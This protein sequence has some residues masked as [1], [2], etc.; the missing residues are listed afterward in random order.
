MPSV[1]WYLLQAAGHGRVVR[2]PPH[3]LRDGVFHQRDHQ[4]SAGEQP[5]DRCA[6]TRRLPRHRHGPG[7]T[8]GARH[9]LADDR[10]P[11]RAASWK[12]SRG[13]ATT[14]SCR[15][16]PIHGFPTT[17]GPGRLIDVEEA[18]TVGKAASAR[19]APPRPGSTRPSGHAFVSDAA[20]AT[21]SIVGFVDAGAL[22][23]RGSRRS[24]DCEDRTWMRLGVSPTPRRRRS[25]RTR[26][27]RGQ[28]LAIRTPSPRSTTVTARRCTDTCV[29]GAR[30][31]MTL[32]SC[33]P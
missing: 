20:A 13:S 11:R 10:R 19:P 25:M 6:R 8:G 12:M 7:L 18:T 3:R 29:P 1:R 5:R 4:R 27:W 23:C 16:L 22:P 28:P 26:P 17:S 31:T 9:R 14:R 33:P 2:H 15:R 21:D 30:P 32:A 24:P